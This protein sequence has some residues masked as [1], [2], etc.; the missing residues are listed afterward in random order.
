MLDYLK[1]RPM[2]I[3]H[4]VTNV[5]HITN[6]SIV[7]EA[8]NNLGSWIVVASVAVD[9]KITITTGMKNHG[10]NL[11][12]LCHNYMLFSDLGIADSS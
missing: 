10:L 4:K 11:F 12:M 3:T 5:I 6:A 1:I 8:M 7:T 2:P 9:P